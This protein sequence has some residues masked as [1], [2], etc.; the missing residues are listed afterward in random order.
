MRDIRTRRVPNRIWPPLVGLA[1][2]L[3]LWDGVAAWTASLP[4]T[5]QLFA[6]RLL[7]SV[8]FVVPLA[9]L[10]WR[11]GG[12]GG[13]DAKAFMV[14]AVLFPT[15]PA[16]RLGAGLIL[17][18][19]PTTL[20]VFSLTVL[21]N[22]VLVGALYPLALL[23]RNVVSGR[24][25][26]V[27]V[28]GRPVNWTD[29]ETTHGRLLQTSEGFTRSGLDLDALRMYLTWRGLSL[30][31]LRADAEGLRNPDTLPA[32]PHPPGD[33][34]VVAD[35]GVA[36]ERAEVDDPWGAQ[37]FLD[38]IEGSAYGTTPEK[39]RDGL[40]VLVAEDEIWVSPGIPFI[41]PM[42]VGLIIGLLYGDL[43]FAVLGS[44]GMV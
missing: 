30:A 24:F 31:D 40:D 44:F 32:D 43:L 2:V 37:T 23:V 22:T 29:L 17:P 42:F 19:E 25:S 14:L 7:L 12:F 27:M 1:V 5:F 26:K 10:F 38:A 39:L 6:I 20:G 15:F 4:G 16:Y 8:A 11:L 36:Q 34:A 28:V 33:G 18:L 21:T 41:L 3:L 9:Y 13:A 35:G